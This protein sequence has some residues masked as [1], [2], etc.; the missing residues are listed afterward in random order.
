LLFQ[1]SSIF[2]L[3][4]KNLITYNYTSQYNNKAQVLSIRLIPGEK[5]MVELIYHISD[6]E[7]TDF[8]LTNVSHD[9]QNILGLFAEDNFTVGEES[10]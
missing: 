7:I 8:T 4:E 10:C 2:N 9:Y 1:S 3:S 6:K 5:L